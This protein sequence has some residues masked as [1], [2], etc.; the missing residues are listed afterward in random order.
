MVA[1]ALPLA[2]LWMILTKQY[3]MEGFLLGY[4]VSVLFLWLTLKNTLRTNYRK[5]PGQMIWLGIY[6]LYVARD[7]VLSGIDVTLRVLNPKLPINP[8]HVRVHTLVDNEI[9]SAMSAYAITIT[10]GEMVVDYEGKKKDIMVVH[11]LNVDKTEQ[12]AARQQRLRLHM[13]KKVLGYD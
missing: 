9:I 12:Q 10:P 8:G 11:S 7:T 5:L 3:S 1:L 4:G 13:L 6:T 2:F